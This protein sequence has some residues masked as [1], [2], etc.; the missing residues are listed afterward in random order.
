MK[1]INFFPEW[2][3]VRF[4]HTHDRVTYSPVTDYFHPRV[5]SLLHRY[6]VSGIPDVKQLLHKMYK[7]N[8]K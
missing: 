6:G 8:N 3:K 2:Y 4:Y 5:A 1:P 7:E